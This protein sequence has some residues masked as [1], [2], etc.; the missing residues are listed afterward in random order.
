VR[1]LEIQVPSGEAEGVGPGSKDWISQAI[2]S[3]FADPDARRHVGYSIY[4]S[5]FETLALATEAVADGADASDIAHEF[6]DQEGLYGDAR[7]EVLDL[8]W[9]EYRWLEEFLA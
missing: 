6:C 7:R 2:S 9:G 8:V 3:E 5:K 4:I 1:Q